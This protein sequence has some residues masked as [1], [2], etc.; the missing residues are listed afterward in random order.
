MASA[1]SDIVRVFKAFCDEN[2]LKILAQLRTG[3]KCACKLLDDL[4]I[5]QPISYRGAKK[6]NGCIIPLIRKVQNGRKCCWNNWYLWMLPVG[7]VRAV[8]INKKWPSG[9]M[10]FL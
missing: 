5:T 6:E 2:R 8:V 9:E 7:R 4:H 1:Y 10:A 3:E